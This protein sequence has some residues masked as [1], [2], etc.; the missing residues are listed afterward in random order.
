MYI[1]GH[2][3]HFEAFAVS[4]RAEKPKMTN[5]PTSKPTN[6]RAGKF[7]GGF[8]G[9]ARFKFRN[10]FFFLLL[11]QGP[12]FQEPEFRNLNLN[13]IQTTWN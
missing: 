7:T 12:A 5:Y 6:D 13:K 10:L 4:V 8:Q 2:V 11:F 9:D 1:P 3:L